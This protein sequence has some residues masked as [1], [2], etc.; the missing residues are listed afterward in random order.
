MANRWWEISVKTTLEL[1][2]IVFWRLEEFGCQGTATFSEEE[3]LIIKGYIPAMNVDALDLASLSF[4][5]RQDFILAGEFSENMT[6]QLIEEEDWSSNWK[7][8]WQPLEIGDRLLIYPAWLEVP[9]KL[10]KTIL[11]LDPGAAFGTGVHETTQLCLESLEMRLEDEEEEEYI[12]ADIGCGSG[13]LSIAAILLRAKEVY[14]VDTDPLAVK[15]TKENSLLNKINHVHVAEGSIYKLRK[16]TDKKM[17]GIV[18][19]ILAEVIEDLIPQMTDI[20]HAKTWGILSGILLEQSS[21]VARVLEKNDWVVATLWKRE[22]WC[23]MNIRR[24]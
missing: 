21:S 5:F 22:E 3:N 17:D 9:E 6:W 13:I 24:Q 2:E 23:C 1:E 12:I 20:V 11:R 16:M 7:E 19:N 15:A 8:Y 10:D 4:W 14:A 18:C